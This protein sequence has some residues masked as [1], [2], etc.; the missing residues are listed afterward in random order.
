VLIVVDTLEK[1]RPAMKSNASAY[2]GDYEAIAGLHKL[3]HE[4]SVAI[5]VSG[6]N[7]HRSAVRNLLARAQ[8]C[9]D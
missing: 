1:L 2:S 9:E 4:R 5:V 7:W 6:R 3:A 8:S